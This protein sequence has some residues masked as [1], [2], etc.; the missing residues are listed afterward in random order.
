MKR[1]ISI[2]AT[3]GF[4]MLVM[5]IDH[6]RDLV[7][8]SALTLDPLDLKVT[9][10]QL[11][12]TRWITHLC[13]PTFV[14]LSGVSAYLSYSNSPDKN[15]A[16]KFLCKRG[17]WLV[18][19]ELSIVN[20]SLWF[21]LHFRTIM[22]Q[23]IAAI[24]FGF[25]LLYFFSNLSIKQNLTISV[26]LTLICNLIAG[27]DFPANPVL[28]FVY[29][30]LA[31]PALFQLTPHF[32]VLVA[33]PVLPWFGIM[34]AGYAC[35]E[36]FTKPDEI[37]SK[38]FL[39]I[40]IVLLLLFVGLRLF[41]VW[42]N[43]SPFAVQKNWPFTLLS[44]INVNKYPPSLL[45]ILITISFAFF[46]LFLSERW[47]GKWKEILSIYGAVPMFYYLLH[48]Y[49]IHLISEGVFLAQG[50]LVNDLNFG[51]FG[52]GRPAGN[53]GLGLMGVYLVWLVVIG[54]LFPICKKYAA[55][56]RLHP[57]KSWMRYI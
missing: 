5:A 57:E 4:V 7:H 12:A 28:N 8:Y 30:W 27:H 9:S 1:I 40:S 43:P 36:L 33:Y 54:L 6:V 51:S 31:S 14:F 20:F 49:L 35:G 18:V 10:P 26:V 17:F 55:Y 25:I 32:I 48:F 47:K 29:H 39:K 56:K 41:N 21:D 52:F 13:A 3:R 24:G 50:Y 2:D 11:F 15:A 23:V 37:R 46:F 22:L 53:A 16:R 38:L 45:F 19:L 34:L 42:G 44:F